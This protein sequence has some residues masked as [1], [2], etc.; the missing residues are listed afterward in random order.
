[1]ARVKVHGVF[2]PYR[3]YSASSRKIQFHRVHGWDSWPVVTWF[4]RVATYA[5]R[6]FATLVL[7]V[8]QQPLARFS[9]SSN[10]WSCT[11]TGI[12]HT[13]VSILRLTTLQRPVVLITSPRPQFSATSK[14]ALLL[15]NVRSEFAEFLNHG[16]LDAW[17]YSTCAPVSG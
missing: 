9:I 3:K 13:S 7:S 17:V 8:I 14:E 11:T 1:M 15:A 5:T 2:S 6:N 10:Y 4:M 12:G 16:S